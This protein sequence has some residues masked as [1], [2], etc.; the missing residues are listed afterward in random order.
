MIQ[1]FR[2][3]M[4]SFFT[5]VGWIRSRIYAGNIAYFCRLGEHVIIQHEQGRPTEY[6]IS[7]NRVQI[8]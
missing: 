1:L 2:R 6:V 8:Q 7:D 4:L 3:S 5:L